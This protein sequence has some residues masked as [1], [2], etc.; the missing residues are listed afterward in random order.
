MEAGESS[1][2]SMGK[3]THES[4]HEEQVPH[5]HFPVHPNRPEKEVPPT[6][7]ASNGKY[8]IP[9]NKTTLAVRVAHGKSVVNRNH[10]VISSSFDFF[11]GERNVTVGSF[12]LQ[13]VKNS[14]LRDV[15]WDRDAIA[16]C[17]G[18]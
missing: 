9:S 14:P 6:R 2:R 18:V 15:A 3:E 7:T 11:D 8:L 13:T 5:K 10:G 12:Q 4:P 1:T 17:L 16:G